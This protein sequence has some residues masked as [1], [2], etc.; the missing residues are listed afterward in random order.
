MQCWRMTHM[1]IKVSLEFLSNRGWPDSL[2]SSRVSDIP[3]SPCRIIL[4]YIS[5]NGVKRFGFFS[6]K[7]TQLEHFFWLSTDANLESCN[8]VLIRFVVS[9]YWATS[10][11]WNRPALCFATSGFNKTTETSAAILLQ[12]VV[13]WPT[14][15][16]VP[17]AFLNPV[18][19]VMRYFWL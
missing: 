3:S 15:A 1:T 11:F 14:L 19:M 4:I 13:L 2:M 16:V 8:C 18:S 10:L 9:Q 6:E 12:D 5:Q 7:G 17:A